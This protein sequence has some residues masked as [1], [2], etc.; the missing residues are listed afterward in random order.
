MSASFDTRRAETRPVRLASTPSSVNAPPL[1]QPDDPVTSDLTLIFG[2]DTRT[3]A[4]FRVGL[5]LLL[6]GDLAWRA[7]DLN[8]FYT[9]AGTL[10]RMTRI[11]LLESSDTSGLVHLWSL[12]MLSGQA[13]MQWL[14]FGIAAAAGLALLIGYRTW[15]ATFVSWILLVSLHARNPVILQG[16]DVLLRMLVFWSLFLPLGARLSIDRLVHPRRGLPRSVLSIGSF[17]LLLQVASLYVF[18][19][20][21]KDH[22]RWH[23]EF[24]AV[25][26][27]LQIDQLT[28]PFGRWLTQF[29][30]IGR[31][32]TAGT[33]YFEL[34]GPVLAFLPWFR[35]WLRFGVVLLF[36]SFHFGLSLCFHLGPFPYYCYVAWMAFVPGCVWDAAVRGFPAAKAALVSGRRQLGELWHAY[37]AGLERTGWGPAVPRLRTSWLGSC[38][39]TAALGVMLVWNLRETTASTSVWWRIM[40]VSANVLGRASGIEQRWDMFSPP[41]TEDGWYCMEGILNNGRHVNLWQPDQGLPMQKRRDIAAMYPRERWRKYLM[42]LCSVT[43]Q[44][45]R[46]PFVDWLAARWNATEA[47][48]RNDWRVREVKLRFFIEETPVPGGRAKPIREAMLWHWIYADPADGL[49]GSATPLTVEPPAQREAKSISDVSKP[50]RQAGVSG[51]SLVD[52]HSSRE[53]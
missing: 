18:S 29:P 43:H 50:S 39:A 19:V 21:M 45:Y 12:H 47:R 20:V 44:A 3:L 28:T 5:A 27:A 13:W 9:D 8:A 16:G 23:E 41:L 14:M 2:I 11:Q 46:G 10:P 4:V 25:Y 36:W 42:N 35:G 37:G 1:E 33:Y 53:P 7:V 15:L 32:L 51:A 52:G 40:P 49:T 30:S 26:Y 34:L 48:G 22:P 31:S 24:S 38:I 6:L 17:A